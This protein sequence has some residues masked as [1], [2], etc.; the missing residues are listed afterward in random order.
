MTDKSREDGWANVIT[1]M[2]IKGRDRTKSN[3]YNRNERLGYGALEDLYIGDGF[4][5][6]VVDLV[7]IEM[8]R[9][10][11]EVNGD[12]D[13]L[14]VQRLEEINAKQKI[15]DL[16]KWA[17]LYGGAIAI[18][19][20][21][22]G[23][24]LT[25]PVNEKQ[26]RNVEFIHVFDRQLV[27]WSSVDLYN[28][29]NNIK[30]GLPEYYTV[31]PLNTGTIFKVHES[32]ILRADGDRVPD[33]VMQ[34]NNGWSYSVLQGAYDQIKN[35][36]SS[37]GIASNILE[38]FVQTILKIDNLQELLASGQDE[39][40]TKRLNIIDMSRH[41]ANTI[42]LDSRESYSKQASSIAG[43]E[44]VIDRFG[45]A[46]AGVTGIPYSFLMG[47][48]PSGLQS[49]GQ[50]DVRMFYDMIKSNQEDKLKPILEKLVRYMMLAKDG[51]FKGKELESW[52]VEFVPLW[53]MDEA[54]EAA[55]RKTVAESDAIYLDRGVLTP[56]EVAISRFGGEMFSNETV[57][58]N[59]SRESIMQTTN[60]G[61]VALDE[62]IKSQHSLK[63]DQDNKEAK[64]EEE[65]LKVLKKL[66]E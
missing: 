33:R 43:L 25:D 26:I 64:L 66:A 10:W 65:Y 45:L 1:N 15:T 58:E 61:S 41:V 2:G 3:K 40:I 42:L 9:Q 35:L 23:G 32:R 54:Q 8:T 28:D 24:E 47:Q 11:I 52:Q 12:T 4:A 50:A 7:P 39:L 14:I 60:E 57:L 22:D 53:Q 20:I 17:R 49:T 44:A 59:E 30:F 55:Y 62:H 27:T 18:M 6:K 38:D 51:P 36:G 56:S 13:N 63:E 46:L 31:T 37:Y 19:G 34:Q 5:K 21:D 16:L 29:P 48:P